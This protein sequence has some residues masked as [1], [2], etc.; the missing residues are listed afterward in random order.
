MNPI[1]LVVAVETIAVALLAV[2]VVGLLRSHAE[3]LRRLPGEDRPGQPEIPVRQAAAR[4]EVIAVPDHLPEPRETQTEVV[5]IEGTTLDGASLVLAPARVDTL[6]AFL[7]S[8]CLTCR[9]FWEGMRSQRS[10]LPGEARLMIVVK[11][12]ELENLS[13]LRELAP[14]G[15]PVVMSSKA[16]ADYAVPMSPYFLFVSGATGT[17]R[18][19][20]AASSWEQVR[21]LL[22]DA[23][24]D[25]A[26]IASSAGEGVG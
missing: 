8:G 12:R 10:P 3:I 24:E 2:V 19:E 23:I 18:S 4:S 7:S 9:T 16:W 17:V 11:D 22:R 26:L 1:E 5:D 21:S 13:R 14:A 6:V 15:V 25:D 20:G